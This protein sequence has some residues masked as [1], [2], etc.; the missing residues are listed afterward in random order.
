MPWVQLPMLQNALKSLL[1]EA[2]ALNMY[3]IPK[4]TSFS[5]PSLS[6]SAYLRPCINRLISCKN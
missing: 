4:Y 5:P 1:P 3:L 6:L 2:Q